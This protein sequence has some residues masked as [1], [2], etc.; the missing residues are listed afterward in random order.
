MNLGKINK[1]PLTTMV[2]KK[3]KKITELALGII[4]PSEDLV[5]NLSL[6]KSVLYSQ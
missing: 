3:K 2:K 6:F 1:Y 4:I 5:I